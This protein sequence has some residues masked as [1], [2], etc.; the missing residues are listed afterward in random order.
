[1]R[2]RFLLKIA[3]LILVLA[4]PLLAA[5]IILM[6]GM[7]THFSESLIRYHL[8]DLI[9]QCEGHY[10]QLERVGLEDSLEHMKEVKDISL[11]EIK[12]HRFADTGRTF[13]IEATG[14]IVFSHRFRDEN[15]PDFKDFFKKIQT[16]KLKTFSA[17]GKTYLAYALYYPRGQSFIGIDIEKK[18]VYLPLYK[19]IT[20]TAVTLIVAVAIGILLIIALQNTIVEPVIHLA[21]YTREVTRG[22]LDAGIEGK[23][24]FELKELKE[25]LESMVSSLKKK[26]RE[27]MMQVET[28]CKREAQLK[29]VLT[30][31]EEEK[32]R[33]KITLRSIGDGVI[34]TDTQGRVQLMNQVA[35]E[36][37]GWEWQEAEKRPL[38]EVFNIV[39]EKTGEPCQSPVSKVMETGMVVG[40]ANHTALI[41]R[42]GTRRIIADS[43]APIKDHTGRIV[44]VVL[45]FRDITEKQHMEEEMVKMEKLRSVGVLAGGIAHDFNNIL[46]AILGNINLATFSTELDERTRRLLGQAEKACIRARDLTYQL[47][48]FSKGGD[49][50]K[51]T[52]DMGEIVRESSE[53]VLRGSGISLSFDFDEALWQVD[54]DPGQLSQVIQ[55]LVINARHAMKDRGTMDIAIKNTRLNAPKG[56]VSPGDWLKITIKDTGPGIPE[57]I[58][59]R[60][61]EPYFTTKEQGS[62]LGLAISYSIIKKHDGVIELESKKGQGTVF[63]IYLPR[64]KET[65]QEDV[66]ESSSHE[67]LKRQARILVIDDEEMVR[68]VAGEMLKHIGHKPCTASSGEEGLALY[69]EAMETGEPFDLV[70]TDLT[71]PGGMDGVEIKDRIIEMNPQARVICASGYANAPVMAQYKEKGFFAAVEK[72]FRLVKLDAVISNSSP[73]T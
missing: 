32:E 22:N 21:N 43:G 53:F 24:S 11:S 57:D 10:K 8:E 1:M 41:A 20:V 14:R 37:T 31:L 52:V 33:L 30:A 54:A 25:N 34:T 27:S 4:G 5:G 23:F 70:I 67:T 2:Q 58:Q 55:N 63:T 15:S 16:G 38:K 64:S 28:I 45:V 69:K 59:D 29:S 9:R 72:P 7:L 35:E 66:P 56:I 68:N 49:P 18:E 42:D 47:L 50:V 40:L 73:G 51:R 60:I 48:T 26:I 39:N 17:G 36:L 3:A 6:D 12:A 46:A 44:G 61:F 13:V 71:L 65:G 19:Y 62:G